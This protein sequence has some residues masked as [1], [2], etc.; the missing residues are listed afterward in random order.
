MKEVRFFYVPEASTQSL[1]PTDEALHAIRVLRL[2]SGDEMFLMDGMGVFYRAKVSS[3]SN[4]HCG[5]EICES[6]S[7]EKTWKGNIHIAMAPTKM[8][9]RVEWFVEKATEIG[10]DTFSFLNC[11]F[12]ERKTMRQDRIDKIV[13]SAMKQSRKPWKPMVNDLISFKEF[14]QKPR[15]GRKFI[16]HCY[17]EV[18]REDLY[19]ILNT[20]ESKESDDE[21]TVLIGPEGDFSLAEV[22]MALDNGYRSITLGKARLRTETAA[23]SAVM[24]AQLSR[25]S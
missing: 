1:L 12:S 13:V 4:K 14:I 18:P 15:E 2:K 10:V 24:M 23:L 22:Q 8:M 3:V 25:R 9:D 16:A 5:Y 20:P 6:L 17:D 7:Q 19:D 21:I 11:Q